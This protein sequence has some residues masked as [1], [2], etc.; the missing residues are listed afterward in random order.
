M[1]STKFNIEKF[2]GMN[3][4]RLCQVRMKALLKQQGLAAALEELPAATIVA[5]DNVIQKKAYSAL[6]LCL[7]SPS[8][9]A[10]KTPID[11]LGLFGWLASIKQEMLEPVKVKCIFLGY[12]KSIVGNKLWR[13][14]DVTSK[15]RVFNQVL[16]GDELRATLIWELFGI[17]KDSNEAA[18]AVAA[19]WRRYMHLI[20]NFNDTVACEL[21]LDYQ[22]HSIN[23]LEGSLQGT[24]NGKRNAENLMIPEHEGFV[25]N[26]RSGVTWDT[27][28]ACKEVIMATR[29][30]V[31]IRAKDSSGYCY[32]CIVKGYPWFVVPALVE[33][34]AYRRFLI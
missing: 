19:K 3:G 4:F 31:R 24:V 23:A 20:I 5:Y 7:G 13:L 17:E 30:R 29:Y 11:M 18:Y 10:F 33:T 25:T 28:E 21:N 15:V 6:I 8:H 14:D 2:D 26:N 1:T 22:G 34:A 27:Y 32:R 9:I 16:Q 12:R